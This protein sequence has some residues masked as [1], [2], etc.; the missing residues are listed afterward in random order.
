MIPLWVFVLI[1]LI[2]MPVFAYCQ[3][4]WWGVSKERWKAALSES[5]ETDKTPIMAVIAWPL[6]APIALFIR[7]I[8]YSVKLAREAG[9][10]AAIKDHVK[11]ALDDTKK[12]RCYRDPET[13]FPT[14]VEYDD[15]RQAARF[16]PKR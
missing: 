9:Q 2:G 3:A 13:Q 5:N 4:R 16:G 11:A 15:L 8:T 7:A 6:V 10:E 14:L 1:Y 12:C